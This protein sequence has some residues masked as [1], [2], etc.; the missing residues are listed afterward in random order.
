MLVLA[1]KFLLAHLIG[2]F[3]LQPD[4]WVKA[5]YEGQRISKYFYYHIGIH[6]IVLLLVMQFE[7]KYWFGML[8]ILISHFIFDIGKMHFQNKKNAIPLFFVDQLLHLVAIAAALYYYE[9]F[10]IDSAIVT[11]PKGVL[12]LVALLLVTQVTAVVL[13]VL[14]SSFK[15]ADSEPNKAG[16]YIG[17]IERV[18][19]FSFVLMNYWEGIGF[20][21]AAKSIFRFGDLNNAKDRSLTEY[22]LIGTL[23]SFGIA[24]LISQVYTHIIIGL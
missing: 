13:K 23:L 21:L 8:W 3:L 18:F 5:K 15:M 4:S 24:I 7:F 14:L 2:D 10:T 19:I 9:P 1:S 16:K 17:M 20:L 22:V 11:S 6:A 12:L